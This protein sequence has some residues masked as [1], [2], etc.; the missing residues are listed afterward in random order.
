[1]ARQGKSVSVLPLEDSLIRSLGIRHRRS[2]LFRAAGRG[3]HER[4]GAGRYSQD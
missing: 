4:P 1:M 3:Q 2:D